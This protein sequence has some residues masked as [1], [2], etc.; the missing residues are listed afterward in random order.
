MI[1][2]NSINSNTK[3]EKKKKITRDNIVIKIVYRGLTAKPWCCL[4]ISS[5]LVAKSSLLIG[6]PKAH[7][8]L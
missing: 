2:N 4:T 5:S 1:R 6:C 7:S 8:G 3:H